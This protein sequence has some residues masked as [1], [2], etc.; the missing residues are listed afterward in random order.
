MVAGFCK[1]EVH[2]H[3]H[4]LE[5]RHF[6]NRL[7][8]SV[9]SWLYFHICVYDDVKFLQ[10]WFILCLEWGTKDSLMK[11]RCLKLVLAMY[12]TMNGRTCSVVITLILPIIGLL[13]DWCIVT[14]WMWHGNVLIGIWET[15]ILD[16]KGSYREKGIES[17]K[18]HMNILRD[19]HACVRFHV[20]L[21]AQKGTSRNLRTSSVDLNGFCREKSNWIL[22]M[23]MKILHPRGPL[24]GLVMV[25]NPDHTRTKPDKTIH[26]TNPH[27]PQ[28]LDPSIQSRPTR[29]RSTSN[30]L[31]SESTKWTGETISD[32]F[33]TTVHTLKEPSIV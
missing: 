33:G 19:R 21:G 10:N 2:E 23:P 12:E 30:P 11:D 5:Y 3:C 17:S 20:E 6:S 8:L 31:Q 27:P 16:P 15:S 9:K 14:D 32:H 4:T 24:V 7:E 26:K 29:T 1:E 18:M 13:Y 28:T 25:W 22:K